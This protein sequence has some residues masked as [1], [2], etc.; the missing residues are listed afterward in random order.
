MYVG[1]S[2]SM[3]AGFKLGE[4]VCTPAALIFL[5][6]AGVSPASL[7]RRHAS[8]DWGDVSEVAAKENEFSV[9]EGYRIL[10]RYPV[11]GEHVW[12]ITKADR[13]ATTILLPKEY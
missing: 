4:V 8:G 6:E 13:S 9:K 12:I 2:S 3:E 10:S 5:E 1:K 7:L 11:G